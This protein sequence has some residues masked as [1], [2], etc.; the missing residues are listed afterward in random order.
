M[1]EKQDEMKCILMWWCTAKL[2]N[3]WVTFE[4]DLNEMSESDLDKIWV[5]FKQEKDEMQFNVI[6]HK[7]N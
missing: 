3:I 7:W 2:K 6:M 4:S 1:F 5:R